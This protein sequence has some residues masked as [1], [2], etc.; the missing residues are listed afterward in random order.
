MPGPMAEPT[1]SGGDG[2][3][4]PTIGGRV[5]RSACIWLPCA[6]L[7]LRVGGLV[8][9]EVPNNVD[10]LDE[11][12]EPIKTLKFVH[13]RGAAF[14]KWGPMPNL[15]Y[16]PVYAVPMA[17]WRLTGGLGRPS[18]DY[19]YGFAR[20]FEQQGVLIV[21]ARAVGLAFGLGCM[22]LYGR[23]L[24]R[25]TGSATAVLIV[26][27]LF[28]AT[29]PELSYKF[30]ATKPDGLMLAF[31]A[32]SMGVYADIAANGLTR[33]RGAWLSALAVGSIS[34]KELTALVYVLPYAGL[35]VA[36]WVRAGGAPGRR[37]RFLADFAFAVA[38]GLVAYALVNVVYAPS[39]WIERMREWLSGP[40]KD[41]DVWA[42][43]GYTAAAYLADTLR[44]LLWNLGPGGMAVVAASLATSLAIPY[45]HRLLAWLPSVG[46]LALLIATAG[47]M[48]TYFLCPLDV[49]LALPVAASLAH[50]GRRLAGAP[51]AVRAILAVAVAAAC[52]A[53]AWQGNL[54][55]ARAEFSAA[56]LQERYCLRHVGRA[57]LIHTG[58]FYV[59]QPGADRLSYLGFNVDDRPLGAL[60]DR[61]SRMPDVILITIEQVD[62]M[63]DFRLRPER[64]EMMKDSGYSYD[65]F[66]G[67]EPL[68]YRLVETLRP[69]TNWLTDLPWLAGFRIPNTAEV[70]VFRKGAAP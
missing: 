15:L 2:G 3:R 6:Y 41:P 33:R 10:V 51:R 23:A 37:R 70:L 66:E 63:N 50:L 53:N 35:A 48:P 24:L 57:E 31:L 18:T 55:R 60:L 52:L 12:Y 47:Y 32:A 46:F 54:A 49:T 42:P 4:T 27:T 1:S 21:L 67:F 7:L 13:S 65:R 9:F 38:A 29:S 44:G 58:N 40:G 11:S 28:M 16:A 8:A 5:A 20:P 68:G 25:F 62:W 39:T 43:P 14:A 69:R 17:Y 36:G 34:C 56:R 22:A 61:P 64:N 59:R 26:L 45:E 19:P 30:V